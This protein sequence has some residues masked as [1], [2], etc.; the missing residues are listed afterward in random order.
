MARPL[1]DALKNSCLPT[2]AIAYAIRYCRGLFVGARKRWGP[3][4]PP[5]QYGTGLNPPGRFTMI[6]AGP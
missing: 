3:K 5:R 6:V 2:P 1:A 4:F